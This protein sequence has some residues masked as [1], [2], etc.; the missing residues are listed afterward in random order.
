LYCLGQVVHNE[1]EVE[2]LSKKGLKFL[3]YQ[4]LSNLKNCKLLLRAHG[5]PPQT[6]EIAARNNI[7]LVDGTCAIVKNIQHRIKRDGLKQDSRDTQIIIF[8]KSNHPEVRGLIA[9]VPDK[10]IVI[11]SVQEALE[12]PL[13]DQINLYSQTTMDS[14]EYKVITD[15]LRERVAQKGGR[16]CVNNTICSHVSHR[17]PGLVRFAKE[18]EVII[19]VAGTNSSNG[20]ML[21]EACK[22]VNDR[23]Y[24]ITDA[25]MIKKEWFRDI[26]SIGISG[27]T[28]TPQWQIEKM[29]NRIR[30]MTTDNK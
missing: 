16:L 28:S 29:Y 27:A 14:G 17:K 3:T 6:Y 12:I 1:L 9:Q 2:R 30:E 11:G 24:Y 18:N 5:E 15:L 26:S 4:D 21:F 19:F 22:A 8:G 7:E 20:R 13:A 25:Q 23:C 10:T